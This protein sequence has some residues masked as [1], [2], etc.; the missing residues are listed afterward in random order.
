MGWGSITLTVDADVSGVGLEVAR[1]DWFLVAPCREKCD[2]N[3][4]RLGITQRGARLHA[5]GRDSSRTR[6]IIARVV[7]SDIVARAVARGRIR[8]GRVAVD[9]PGVGDREKSAT[10]RRAPPRKPC[11]LKGRRASRSVVEELLE[12]HRR[13]SSYSLKI[14]FMINYIIK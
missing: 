9:A 7:A 2:A 3:A 1:R 5:R 10:P 6:K 14:L 13:R 11:N 8:C 4:P 12:G